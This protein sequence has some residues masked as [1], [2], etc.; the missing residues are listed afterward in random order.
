MPQ[1]EAFGM[2]NCNMKSEFD[3]KFLIK[4]QMTKTSQDNNLNYINFLKHFYKYHTERLKYRDII[5][6]TVKVLP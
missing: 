1:F 3:Q 5:C 4:P 2:I 6:L